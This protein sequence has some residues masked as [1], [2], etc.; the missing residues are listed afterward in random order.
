M[1]R[2]GLTEAA[3]GIARGILKQARSQYPELADMYK[4]VRKE[5]KNTKIKLSDQDR[6]DLGEMGGYESFRKKYFG[7]ITLS[8]DGISIDSLYQE[9]SEQHPELFPADITHP[10]DQLMAVAHAIDQTQEYVQ[11]P[12]HADM[13]E[14]SYIVG[15]E[16]IQSYFEIQNK[17]P[18]FADQKEAQLSLIH[19]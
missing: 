14:M 8:K 16:I 2:D 13:D 7:K 19:I 12:Y 4:G 11:N 5:I 1:D 15:Q 18:T 10:A 3:T 6:A 9:L 17:I